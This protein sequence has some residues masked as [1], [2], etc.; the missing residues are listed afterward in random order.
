MRECRSLKDRS[1]FNILHSRI[2]FRHFVFFLSVRAQTF[3]EGLGLSMGS[4]E[5]QAVVAELNLAFR[6]LTEQIGKVIV[7]QER[8]HRAAADRPCSRAAIACSSAC[9]AWPRRCWSARSP[10][11]S[12][13]SFSRIQFTPDLMP[14]DITGTEVMQEDPT[15][16]RP[17]V[18]V[19]A[20]PDLRQHDPGRRNQPHAAEDAGRPARG[21]A[22]APG[23]GR[24]PVATRCPSRSSCW[25][26]RTRS[27]RK[28][29]IRCPRRSSTASCS[30]S[31][32]AIRAATRSSRS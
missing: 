13:L 28:A 11:S 25:P 1:S 6:S 27:S 5:E 3:H 14:A 22:G 31:S 2:L 32:S 23:H 12:H 24:R 9:R 7:G 20:G 19:S 30:T 4:P 16:G 8:G 26:R 21:H 10:T 18:P 17:A 15:T 29:P